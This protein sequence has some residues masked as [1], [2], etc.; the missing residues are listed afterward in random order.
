MFGNSVF[1]QAHAGASSIVVTGEA[2]E[3][4]RPLV[5]AYRP[6]G[7]TAMESRDTSDMSSF[8]YARIDL[9]KSVETSD[10]V[11]FFLVFYGLGLY[12]KS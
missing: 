6:F 9:G 7:H 11:T 12:F 3:Y 8:S 10:V 2:G 1:A 4:R 5:C